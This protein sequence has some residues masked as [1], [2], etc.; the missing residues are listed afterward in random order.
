MEFFQPALDN[1]LHAF[2]SY[3]LALP[4]SVLVSFVL[5]LVF[6]LVFEEEE[7]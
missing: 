4:I 6:H 7:V 3:L 5:A 2:W 1:F